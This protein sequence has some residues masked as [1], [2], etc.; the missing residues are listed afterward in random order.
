MTRTYLPGILA[1]AT[2][3]VASNILV[4][5]LFGQWLTWGAFTYPLRVPCDGPD[6]PH[7]WCERRAPRNFRGLRG[8]RYL[9]ADRY[10]DAKANSARWSHFASQLAPERRSLW[11]S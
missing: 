1:M 8:R 4:Q 6:E 9:L 11:H 2:I 7:L 10:T 3:V 5:F